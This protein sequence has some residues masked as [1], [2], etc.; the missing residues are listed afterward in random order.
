MYLKLSVL[1]KNEVWLKKDKQRLDWGFLTQTYLASSLCFL[2]CGPCLSNTGLP[3]GLVRKTVL[4]HVNQNLCFNK[5]PEKLFSTHFDV[6][7]VFA[8]IRSLL[9]G[10]Q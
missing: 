3:W 9:I 7:A 5:I 1:Q 4:D 8:H 6:E 10:T 2:R